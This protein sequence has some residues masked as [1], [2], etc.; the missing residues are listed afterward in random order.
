MK[1]AKK[2]AAL[3]L[4]MVMAFSCLTMSAL[5]HDEKSAEYAVT[6]DGKEIMPRGAVCYICHI[7][8]RWINGAK[9]DTV[10][11]PVNNKYT[12]YHYM[13]GTFWEC[14]NCGMYSPIDLTRNFWM[15][16]S[17][18]SGACSALP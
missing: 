4:A 3:V 2:L 11:C 1:K 7:Q 8:Q 14:P 6:C 9:T 17:N 15:C 5:A 16:D 13:E 12:H 10:D 18:P